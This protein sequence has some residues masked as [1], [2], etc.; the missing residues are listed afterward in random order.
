MKLISR[1]NNEDPSIIGKIIGA[2]PPMNPQN[3]KQARK[4]ENLLIAGLILVIIVFSALIIES[5]ANYSPIAPTFHNITLN[6]KNQQTIEVIGKHIESVELQGKSMEPT[7]ADG[8]QLIEERMFTWNDI[9]VGDIITFTYQ[10]KLISHR[11]IW[12]NDTHFM[13][14]GD[15]N[16]GDDTVLPLDDI[17][18]IIVGIIY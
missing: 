9:R 17:R 12:K 18:G 16:T 6:E 2:I 13:S 11:L 8:S 1:T 4:W 15:N 14:K 5:R 10:N 3:T 7:I